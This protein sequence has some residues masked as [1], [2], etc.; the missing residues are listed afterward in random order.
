MNH[1]NRQA[2]RVSCHKCFLNVSNVTETSQG[3]LART[4]RMQTPELRGQVQDV[5]GCDAWCLVNQMYIGVMKNAGSLPDARHTD[6]A[7]S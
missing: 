4:V 1:E 7:L 6:R 5:L 3:S 2:S